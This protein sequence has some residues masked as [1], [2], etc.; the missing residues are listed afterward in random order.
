[1]NSPQR[2]SP[3]FEQLAA[4]PAQWTVR[5]EQQVALDFVGQ[6]N[7]AAI[8]G[9]VDLSH[10]SRFGCKGPNAAQWLREQGLPVPEQPNSWSA[11]D[12]DGPADGLVARLGVGE[13][14]V[15]A[16]RPGQ[17]AAR[18]AARRAKARRARPSATNGGR[19][20]VTPTGTAA[21][22]GRA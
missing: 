20:A 19:R 17:P 8:A 21:Q 10:R 12:T 11:F 14:L 3:V 16:A 1:M 7:A 15:E 9:I 2:V 6:P 13:F 18:E 5:N 4:L 22:G